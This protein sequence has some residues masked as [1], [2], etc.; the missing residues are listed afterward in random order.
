ML[1]PM[2]HSV[3]LFYLATQQHIL[4]RLHHMEAV[5]QAIS[6]EVGSIKQ[7]TT[8]MAT[9]KNSVDVASTQVASVLEDLE[10]Q[11]LSIRY[12]FLDL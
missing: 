3:H 12:I 4:C 1:A 10:D 9:W 11:V 5:Y 2:P 7:E 6:T 8:S